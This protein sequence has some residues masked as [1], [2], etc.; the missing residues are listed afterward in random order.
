MSVSDVNKIVT[1]LPKQIRKSLPRKIVAVRIG[2]KK[3]LALNR[4]FLGKNKPANVLSFRYGKN[5]GEILVCLYVIHKEAEKQ[6]NA[7]HYQMTWM[8]VHGMLHLAGMHHEKSK[9]A[10]VKME[11]TERDILARLFSIK[12]DTRHATHDK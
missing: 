4:S 12:S 6:G 5:Y 2:A 10:A 3:V 7:Y 8:I 1:C 9:A 11:K